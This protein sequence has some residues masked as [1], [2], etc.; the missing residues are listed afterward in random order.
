[1]REFGSLYSAHFEEA[2]HFDLPELTQVLAE[3]CSF[4]FLSER[5][6]NCLIPIAPE[7]GVG[8]L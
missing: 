3:G 7:L 1:M 2:L 4:R 6:T 8:I 5:S